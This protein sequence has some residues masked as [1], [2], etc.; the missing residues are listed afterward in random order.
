MGDVE[1]Q[2][3]LRA[4]FGLVP[5]L[6][7]RQQENEADKGVDAAAE[8][9]EQ[10]GPPRT[11]G[12]AVAQVHP[13]DVEEADGQDQ[14]EENAPDPGGK[15]LTENAHRL[16]EAAKDLFAGLLTHVIVHGCVPGR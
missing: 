13:G 10:G 2:H 16:F 14:G 3:H 9:T 4:L 7:G 1:E 6:L 5:R 12:A 15:G 11:D 8:Q